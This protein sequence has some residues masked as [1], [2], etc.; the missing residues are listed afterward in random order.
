M[1]IIVADKK[2]ETVQ[3]T[4]S[5]F[6]RTQ[7]LSFILGSKDPGIYLDMPFRTGIFNGMLS[8]S[9]SKFRSSYQSETTRLRDYLIAFIEYD[10]MHGYQVSVVTTIST[11][12]KIKR[13][14]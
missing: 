7:I 1:T 2:G 12:K 14:C 5:S 3:V 6:A 10:L 8:Q 11:S 13:K 9:V 4:G